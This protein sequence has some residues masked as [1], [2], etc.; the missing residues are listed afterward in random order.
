MKLFRNKYGRKV[1]T[2]EDDVYFGEWKGS[3]FGE[4]WVADG[5]GQLIRKGR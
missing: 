4:A 1:P 2:D 5:E 3:E